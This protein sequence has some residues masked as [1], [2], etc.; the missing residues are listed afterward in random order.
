MKRKYQFKLTIHHRWNHIIF[1]ALTVSL[2]ILCFFFLVDNP[3]SWL[4]RLT[5]EEHEIVDRRTKDNAVVSTKKINWP[6]FIEALKEPR[7][8]LIFIAAVGL[9][10][11]NGGLLVFSAQ[12][13]RTL[14]DFT[15]SS[16][17]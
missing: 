8:Y 17:L 6:H 9:N 15:V 5:P 14:G 7:L 2:G 3:R 10:M 16:Y 12:M 1:G 13:I 4:L 11:Q